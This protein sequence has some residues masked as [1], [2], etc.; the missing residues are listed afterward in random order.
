MLSGLST[1]LTTH[2]AQAHRGQ[3]NASIRWRLPPLPQNRWWVVQ[4]DGVW[5]DGRRVSAFTLFAASLE[6]G[7]TDIRMKDGVIQTHRDERE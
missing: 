4:M 6:Q 2:A 1:S 3:Q 5:V 7:E